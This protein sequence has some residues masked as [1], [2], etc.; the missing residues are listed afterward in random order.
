MR[1]PVL[2]SFIAGLAAAAALFSIWVASGSWVGLTGE[3]LGPDSY[4]R[5]TRVLE[6]RGGWECPDGLLVRANAPFGTVIHWP[7]LMDWLLMAVAA[8]FLLFFPFP[9]A[10]ATA[11]YLLGPILQMICL[12]LVIWG[13]RWVL[14][15]GLVFVG[16][17]M[18]SQLMVFFVFLPGRPDH[19]GLQAVLFA[20][21]FASTIP[22]LLRRDLRFYSCMTGILAGLAMWVSTE[23]L[24]TL[25]PVLLVLAGVWAY[26]GDGEMAGANR[27]IML[28]VFLTLGVALLIDGPEPN[29]WSPDF[30][31]FSIVHIII[32]ALLAFLWHF[33]ERMP[34]RRPG[35]RL[36]AL[37]M[38]GLGVILAMIGLATLK[39]R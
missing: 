8:P 18:A 19:H 39:V 16:L 29:R 36:G 3:F 9:S 26:E 31:R 11:G 34:I 27:R 13:G 22:V 4:M 12:V 6:C 1:K 32:F 14:R 37:A 7:W 15:Q 17:L 2:L 21:F 35:R 25:P 10:L 38:G 23:A 5:L 30:D 33:L 20:G 28:T 24:V